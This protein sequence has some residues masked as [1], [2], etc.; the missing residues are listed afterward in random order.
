MQNTVGVPQYHTILCIHFF[1]PR[2]DLAHAA[3]VL[4]KQ[5]GDGR[6]ATWHQ[7]RWRK[8]DGGETAT[9]K[10]Y[11]HESSVRT[12]EVGSASYYRI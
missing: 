6:N 11:I 12:I 1:G 5:D 8:N 7:N 4:T 10:R 3:L 2:T 9:R